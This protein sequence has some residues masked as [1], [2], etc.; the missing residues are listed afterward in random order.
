M[1]IQTDKL[2]VGYG[3]KVVVDD[4]NIALLEGQFICLLGPNGSGK[5]TILKTLVH[6]LL[7]LGGAVFL[8]NRDITGLSNQEI[9][10]TTAVVLT[11]PITPGLLTVYD[12]VML[13]RHPHTG[14]M[15]KPTA[16]D[17]DKV[18]ESLRLVN[19]AD[20][21][22][23]Y[24]SELSDG[25]KQKV[26]LARALAQEPRLIVLDEPTSHLD[27]RHRI[28]VMLILR[29]LTQEKG[30]TVIASLHDVDLALK[31]CDVA[32]LVKDGQI[33]ACGTPEDVLQE[34]MVARLYG[35]EHA[36]FSAKLGG[37]EL[38][39]RQHGPSVFVVAGGG[40][41]AGVYRALTKHRVTIITGILP[42]NDID[43]LIA[44]AVG[45]ETITVPAYEDIDPMV[46]EQTCRKLD[47]AKQIIDAGFAVG[48]AN[49][50]NIDLIKYVL[51]KNMPVSTLRNPVEAEKLYGT[52]A[53]KLQYCID[54]F[55]LLSAL[56]KNIY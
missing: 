21:A 8:N 51:G 26:M 37:V 9:S 55:E 53:V 6:M 25:E 30:V 17:S 48:S 44:R 38:K 34:E 16:A 29:Q 4:I 13:G 27:A 33:L 32:I 3:K 18:F 1:I 24:F 45:L 35:M 22:S 28:E 15:G 23:R 42:E 54:Y 10:M 2:K 11:D 46:F 41:A 40:A 39:S 5:S 56:R 31:I 36:A 43:Y 49:R 47:N 20:L 12:I 52:L 7:P 19:A 50:L 14:F